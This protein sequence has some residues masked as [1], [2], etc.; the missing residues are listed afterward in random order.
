MGNFL[1]ILIL[2]IFVV[3]GGLYLRTFLTRKAIFRV[4]EIFYEHGAIGMTG[5]K[6]MKELG[7]EQ[8]DLF[9]RMTRPRDYKQIALQ[10][11]IREGIIRVIEDRR[12]YMVEEKLDQDLRKNRSLK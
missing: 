7:L 8:P 4:I 2:V 12:L 3:I 6:T 11:L 10:V 1:I 9:Q 5:A